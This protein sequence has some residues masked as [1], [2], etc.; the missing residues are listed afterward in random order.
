MDIIPEI[1]DGTEMRVA[2]EFSRKY[3]MTIELIVN[4]W[5]DVYK[6][7]TGTGL[8]GN[9]IN[10]EGDIGFGKVSTRFKQY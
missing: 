4:E 5:G 6:N 2:L 7:W 9:L 3:N 8:V 1:P 10:D